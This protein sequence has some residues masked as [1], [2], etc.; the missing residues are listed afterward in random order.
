MGVYFFIKFYIG[1]ISI[2]N[3]MYGGCFCVLKKVGVF[4]RWV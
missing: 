4:I 1:G 3:I 2:Y